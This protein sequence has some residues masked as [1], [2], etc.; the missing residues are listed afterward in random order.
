MTNSDFNYI[1]KLVRDRTGVVLSEDKQYL[2]ES[3][4]M[5]LAKQV[6]ANSV[7]SLVAQLQQKPFHPLCQSVVEAMMTTETFFFRD[8][9]PFQAL[10]NAIIPELIQQRQTERYLTIWCA[11]CSSGQ[12]PYSI[13]MLLR[14]HFPALTTWRVQLIASDISDVMLNR[15]RSGY[16]HPHEMNR[17]LPLNLRQ[18]Y[19]EPKGQGWT[20]K[21]DIRQMVEF[22]PI[23]LTETVL[24]LSQVDIIFLRNVLIY[25]DIE[26][27][28]E[29]LARLRRV[30]QPDGYLFLGGGETTINLDHAFE[31]VQLDNAVCY[32]LR[33]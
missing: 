3:R 13:A 24:P 33:G 17:G 12:E 1:R 16:Y 21:P 28:Q 26:M 7:K 32:K 5:G 18:K 8:N 9:N 2:V 25:F 22:R 4:L 19:F 29:I 15:A 23:N 14:E 20:I 30:L 27:K 10:K 11:A 31:P 6:G